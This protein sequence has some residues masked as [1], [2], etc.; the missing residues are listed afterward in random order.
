M[1]LILPKFPGLTFPRD[2]SF[3]NFNTDVETSVGG[4]DNFY[5]N[6][7]N[8]KRR[9]TLNIEGLDRTGNNAVLINSSLQILQSFFQ[10]CQGRGLS[11]QYCDDDD[12]VASASSFGIGDGVSTV[13]QLIRSSFGFAENVH[14]PTGVPS[15][16]S[17]GTRLT[18]TTDYTISSTGK[19]TFTVAPAGA[20]VLTW[21][22]TYNWWCNWDS[23]SL[24]VSEYFAGWFEAQKL[25][26]TTRIFA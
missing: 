14:A 10:Q 20:A 11:F 6:Q 15:I 18:P 22:G 7:T 16:Y 3:G 13:F 24:D 23:D 2:I 8:P 19:V 5:I 4:I 12:S 21:T 9:Y 26:F 17:N 1:T 25:T